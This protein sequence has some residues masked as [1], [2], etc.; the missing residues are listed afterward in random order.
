LESPPLPP[1]G[2]PVTASTAPIR[3][4]SLPAQPATTSGPQVESYDEETYACQ[5]T[6][7]FRTISQTY[8]HSDRF[9]RALLLFNRNHPLATEAVKQEPPALQ[10]G[11]TVYIPPQRILERYYG[12]AIP[13]D[14]PPA[15]PKSYKVGA[16]GEMFLEI[17]RRTLNDENRWADIYRL[18]PSYDPSQ[19]IPAGSELRLP[20]DARQ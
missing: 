10:Q 6:D 4:P 15:P 14:A 8:Y 13:S 5:P 1:L 18:N 17:A 3:A 2:A 12:M 19:P 9:E 16:N 11:Q 7:S 20:P